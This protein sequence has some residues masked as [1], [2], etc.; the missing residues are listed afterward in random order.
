[1]T[2]KPTKNMT[3][4][5]VAQWRRERDQSWAD[6]GVA[7]IEDLFRSDALSETN[8]DVPD[9]SIAGLSTM[10]VMRSV[11]DPSQSARAAGGRTSSHSLAALSGHVE[12]SAEWTRDRVTILWSFSGL[13]ASAFL[14]AA[15]R[16]NEGILLARPFV[17]GRLDDASWTASAADLG[18]D[19]EAPW[20]L[21]MLLIPASL[22]R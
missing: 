2:D 11:S 19:L 22:S 15:F 20:A 13:S 7:V 12:L 10:W 6:H 17:L 1:M 21:E 18:I 5:E 14:I 8:D 3:A 4:D 9:A 16:S